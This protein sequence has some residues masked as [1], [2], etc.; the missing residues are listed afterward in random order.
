VR[1][2]ALGLDAMGLDIE[3]PNVLELDSMEPD[4]ELDALKP[5]SMESDTGPEILCRNLLVWAPLS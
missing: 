2:D 3:E 5:D 1:H 4:G